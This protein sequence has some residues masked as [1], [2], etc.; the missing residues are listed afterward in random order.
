MTT[1]RSASATPPGPV[2][3]AR[4]I[5]VLISGGKHKNAESV[6]FLLALERTVSGDAV[7]GVIGAYRVR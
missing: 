3:A 6:V 2:R 1:L 5:R 4:Q 7:N